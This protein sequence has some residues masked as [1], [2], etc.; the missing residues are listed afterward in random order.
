MRVASFRTNDGPAYGIV[1]GDMLRPASAGFRQRHPTLGDALA[2]DALPAL[3]ADVA[4]VPAIPLAE[5]RLLPPTAGRVICVGLNYP[6]D[7]QVP[8][9]VARTARMI[10]FSRLPGTLVGH[11]EKLEMPAGRAAGTFDYEGEICAVI[12]RPGRDIPE[13]RAMD[14]I[15][16]YTAMNDGTVREW[17][18]HSVHAAKNFFASGSCGPWLTTADGIADPEHMRLTTRL[19][20]T[21]VQA[22]TADRMI[23]KLPEI[24]AYVSSMLP[25][26]PG[27]IIATG[28]PDGAGVSRTPPRFLSAGDRLE[29]EV[30]G[31]GV[32]ANGVAAR[33]AVS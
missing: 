16:G 4:D 25:L 18:T 17:L 33:G 13:D 23:F 32:L 12:G 11:G 24:V 29:I 14:H 30:D 1:E 31:V 21:V 26:E 5:I 28:S 7:E 9:A 15:A 8:E 22:T 3:A 27:D 20:G 10:L 19:N 6:K 2:A